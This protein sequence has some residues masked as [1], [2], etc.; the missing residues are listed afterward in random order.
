METEHII[1]ELS[2]PQRRLMIEAM[3]IC[4]QGSRA[5]DV[6]RVMEMLLKHTPF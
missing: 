1:T 5:A 6:R 3:E 4:L 2:A